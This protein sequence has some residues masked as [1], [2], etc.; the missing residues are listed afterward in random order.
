M[1]INNHTWY[2]THPEK[3]TNLFNKS[4]D[5]IL[6]MLDLSKKNPLEASLNK[7][8][9]QGTLVLMNLLAVRALGL[10]QDEVKKNKISKLMKPDTAI[11]LPN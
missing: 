7:L 10:Q 4:T 11:K 6:D 5:L 9:L 3:S 1:T 8:D 2:N